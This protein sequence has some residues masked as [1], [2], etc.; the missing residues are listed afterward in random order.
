MSKISQVGILVIFTS[1]VS[2][3]GFLLNAD[4]INGHYLALIGVGV[5]LIIGVLYFGLRRRESLKYINIFFDPD[6]RPWYQRPPNYTMTFFFSIFGG[7]IAVT[8]LN[9][10]PDTG[11]KRVELYKV[12]KISERRVRYDFIEYL[13]LSNGTETITYRPTNTQSFAIGQEVKVTME[14]GLLGFSQVLSAVAKNS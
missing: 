1:M 14:K 4:V 7:M 13:E 10:M 9:N 6:K 11:N 8:L 5:G 2:Q 12:T 3:M